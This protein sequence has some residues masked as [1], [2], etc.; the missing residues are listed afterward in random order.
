MDAISFALRVAQ[1]GPK[2]A[3][4][5][6][7]QPGRVEIGNL[8][9]PSMTLATLCQILEHETRRL[10]VD[11]TELRD[12]FVI[13]LQWARDAAG[14]TAEPDTSRPSQR[15]KEQF[16]AKYGLVLNEDDGFDRSPVIDT[17]AVGWRD[18]HTMRGDDPVG[19]G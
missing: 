7:G 2:L 15:A 4:A 16:M 9:A 19:N 12:S 10:V 3:L 8:S 18:R 14:G 11:Q 5:K 1:S 13:E 6:E 17:G